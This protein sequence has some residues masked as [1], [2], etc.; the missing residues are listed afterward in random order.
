[1]S[2]WPGSHALLHAAMAFI[3]MLSEASMLDWSAV[4]L[5]DKAGM[6]DKNAGIGYTV[7]SFAITMSRLGGNSIIPKART[8]EDHIGGR[9]LGGGWVLPLDVAG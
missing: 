2:V 5:V 1:M 4:F 9:V 3:M 8:Q 6:I 7:F